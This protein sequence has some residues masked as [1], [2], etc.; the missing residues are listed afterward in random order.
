MTTKYKV[1]I[2]RYTRRELDNQ[3]EWANT[4][5]RYWGRTPLWVQVVPYKSQYKVLADDLVV[6]SGT[7]RACYNKVRKHMVKV[8]KEVKAEVKR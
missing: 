1:H 4:W 2:T 7:A 5:L 6:A 3:I 8:N